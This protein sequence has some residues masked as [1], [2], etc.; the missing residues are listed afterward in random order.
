[1]P[2]VNSPTKIRVSITQSERSK[3]RP[4]VFDTVLVPQQRMNTSGGTGTR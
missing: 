2:V 4:P 1:V 3:S